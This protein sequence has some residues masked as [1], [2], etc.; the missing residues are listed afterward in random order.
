MLTVMSSSSPESSGDAL[1]PGDTLVA[2]LSQNLKVQHEF[3][4][5]PTEQ[6]LDPGE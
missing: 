2:V 4:P 3:L 1:L 5:T 6:P